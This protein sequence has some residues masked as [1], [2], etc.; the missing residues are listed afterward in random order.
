[1]ICIII[2]IIVSDNLLL[3]ILIHCVSFF[4]ISQTEF[5][6]TFLL[7][8]TSA[9]IFTVGVYLRFYANCNTARKTKNNAKAID[10][11]VYECYNTLDFYTWR[12]NYRGLYFS[13]T[14]YDNLA[15]CPMQ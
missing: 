5:Y 9:V 10:K 7:K 1:M 15:Y 6:H 2:A 4:Q 12:G 11:K 13:C 3:F 8:V 14:N